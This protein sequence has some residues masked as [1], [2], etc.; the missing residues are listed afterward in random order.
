MPEKR[1]PGSLFI[2]YHA[3]PGSETGLKQWLGTLF[4]KAGIHG[5]L[6]VRH[7]EGKTTFMETYENIGCEAL[8]TIEGLA[9]EQACFKSVQRRCEAFEKIHMEA[10]I[11]KRESRPDE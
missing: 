2:W 3:E 9:A 6:F 7:A 1:P 4:K 5:Q 11:R 8:E 10:K